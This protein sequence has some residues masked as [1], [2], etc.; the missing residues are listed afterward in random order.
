MLRTEIINDKNIILRK[1]QSSVLQS[2]NV[3][4]SASKAITHLTRG[5]EL[6]QEY[7]TLC[8]LCHKLIV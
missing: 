5:N 1:S 8:V 6:L 2:K 4:W 7:L 3:G